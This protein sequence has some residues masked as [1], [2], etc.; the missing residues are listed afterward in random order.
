MAESGSL[1]R[2]YTVKSGIEGSNPSLSAPL[3]IQVMSEL[4]IAAF[5]ERLVSDK[6]LFSYLEQCLVEWETDGDTF[7]DHA[8]HF[9]QESGFSV[10]GADI[11]S[12]MDSQTLSEALLNVSG[13]GSKK[14]RLPSGPLTPVVNP[15][16]LSGET[17][18]GGGGVFDHLYGRIG[19]RG[20]D[21]P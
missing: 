19:P 10:S 16:K 21:N 15:K 20:P 1:L 8:A 18:S 14:K 4:R 5:I 12:S 2:S 17:G 6:E 3:S 9:A 11:R 13:G 7:Y